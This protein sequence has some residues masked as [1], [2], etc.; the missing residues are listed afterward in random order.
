MKF[1]EI[2]NK[3][4]QVMYMNEKRSKEEL[5]GEG[6]DTSSSLSVLLGVASFAFSPL[7]MILTLAVTR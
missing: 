3:C 6:M 7:K 4:A 1:V 5:R 2:S